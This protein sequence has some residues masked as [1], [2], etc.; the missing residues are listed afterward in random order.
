VRRTVTPGRRSGLLTEIQDGLEPG[1]R[2]ILHPGQ[3]IEPGRRVE[4]R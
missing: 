4:A 2:V 1:E 3:D